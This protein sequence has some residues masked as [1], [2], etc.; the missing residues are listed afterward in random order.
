M[1]AWLGARMAGPSIDR[2]MDILIVYLA[3]PITLDRAPH[4]WTDP[5]NARLPWGLHRLLT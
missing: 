1:C 3:N 2:P 5:S 4:W